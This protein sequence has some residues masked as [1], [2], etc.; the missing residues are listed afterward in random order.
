MRSADT[1]LSVVRHATVLHG[2][3]NA[4]DK[5]LLPDCSS[6]PMMQPMEISMLQLIWNRKKRD[7]FSKIFLFFIFVYFVFVQMFSQTFQ[8]VS[9]DLQL[10]FYSIRKRRRSINWSECFQ[11][12][13]CQWLKR[14]EIETK[15]NG[16]KGKS[17]LN[18]VWNYSQDEEVMPWCGFM[19]EVNLVPW[20]YGVM[21][22]SLW[23][24]YAGSVAVG[25]VAAANPWKSNLYA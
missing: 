18:H 23:Y 12:E 22:R 15:K 19:N 2:S 13:I 4:M 1:S 5:C 14:N 6:C 11:V 17:G 21:K 25:C 3:S 9:Y 16:S 24:L 7:L 10:F 8:K 20:W